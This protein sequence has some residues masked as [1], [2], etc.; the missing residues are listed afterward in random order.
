MANDVVI[1][2]VFGLLMAATLWAAAVWR[3]RQTLRQKT[4]ALVQANAALAQTITTLKSKQAHREEFMAWVGHELRTPMNAILGLNPLLRDSLA[5]RTEDAAMVDIVHRSTEQLL[6]VVNHLL[7]F[8]Q[9]EAGRLQLREDTFLLSEALNE[10]FAMVEPQ[11]RAK[12]LQVVRELLPHDDLRV[13]ADRQRLIQLLWHLLDNAIKF[14]DLGE[15]RLRARLSPDGLHC[16][17]EDTGIGIPPDRRPEIFKTA[18]LGLSICDR[19]VRLQGGRLGM[20]AAAT[21]GSV[22]WF[23]VPI[24]ATPQ[25]MHEATHPRSP[26]TNWVA[27]PLQILLVDD[28]ELNLIVA[29]HLVRKCFPHATVIEASCGAQALDILRTQTID[30]ALIDM[31]MPEMDGLQLTMALRCHF[32][33]PVCHLPVLALTASN[34]PSDLGRCLSVGMNGVLLKPLNEKRVV[35]QISQALT[36]AAERGQ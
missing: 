31:L 34:D 28:H 7:D 20:N 18:G 4:A 10:V 36:A 16:E 21:G 22:F 14:T 2:T 35:A 25:I 13:I 27:E 29:R 5:T 23:E 19:L 33:P 8:S 15:V 9:L 11:A 1:W 17:V 26:A 24:Q 12:G 32:A 6:Q 30:L 3:Y